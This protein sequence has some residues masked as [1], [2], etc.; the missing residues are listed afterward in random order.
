MIFDDRKCELGE[1]P[2]WHPLRKQLF[3]FDIK[4]KRLLTRSMAGPQHWDFPEMVSAA[5]WVSMDEL[6]IASETALLR[7]NL[8][9]GKT[10]KVV[11]LEAANPATRSND[12]RAD[13]K[14]GFW[15]STMSKSGG[16]G[17][18]A[19]GSIWRYWRG[20]L[21]RL[22]SPIAIPNSICFHP[23]GKT[24]FFSDTITGK[25]MRTELDDE[26]WPMDDP[27]VFLD[28]SAEGLNPDGAVMD[29]EG[30]LW[31]AE[32]GA[33]RVSV[34]GPDGKRV[35]S[36]RFDAPHTSCPAFGG[37]DLATL[38]CTSALQNMDEDARAQHPYAGM[39]FMTKPIARGQAEHQVIL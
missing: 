31:L 16:P 9:T 29:H 3:W 30:A 26:G 25:V 11:A 19:K 36:L 22:F 2:L 4:G 18:K 12:G 27:K 21:R 1:G 7:F 20:T 33:S 28:L 14:G 5:G 34:Y 24:A 37:E 35:R 38:F 6:L 13:P 32:W 10:A 17:A 15:I 23:N 8:K 39:T